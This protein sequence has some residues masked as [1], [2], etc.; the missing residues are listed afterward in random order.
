MSKRKGSRVTRA[1]SEK[2]LIGPCSSVDL[3]FPAATRKLPTTHEVLRTFFAHLGASSGAES[4]TS[5]ARKTTLKLLPLWE[6]AGVP[7]AEVRNIIQ[8]IVGVYKRYRGLVKDKHLSGVVKK[9]GSKLGQTHEKNREQFLMDI[10]KLFD[11]GHKNALNMMKNQEDI[12]FYKSM[13]SDRKAYMIGLD[14]VNRDKHVR[15]LE[16]KEAQRKAKEKSELQKQEMLQT[17]QLSGL[18]ELSVS[19]T[20]DTDDT[21][22]EFKVEMRGEN[23][24]VKVD[25]TKNAL[26][27]SAMARTSTSQYAGSMMV[28]AIVS[29]TVTQLGYDEKDVIIV[30]SATQIKRRSRENNEEVSAI[31]KQ[32]FEPT[33]PLVVHFDGKLFPSSEDAAKNADRLPIVVSGKN[34]EKLLGIPELVH[35]SG[36]CIADAVVSHVLD[37]DLK[38][39]IIGL[40]FD[41]TSTNSGRWGG[42]CILIQQKLEMQLLELACRHHVLELVLGAV[43]DK[44]AGES[45]SPDLLYGDFLK[46]SWKSLDK[47]NYRTAVSLRGVQKLLPEADEM[48]NF[49]CDQLQKYQPRDDYKELLELTIVFLGGVVPEKDPY[50]FRTPGATSKTRWMAKALYSFKIWMFGKQL[51]L[52]SAESDSF[53]RVCAFLATH[54]V[55]NWYECPVAIKAPA[56]DLQLLKNLS[57]CKEPYLKAAF[58]KLASHLWYL[59]EKLICLA[60]FDNRVTDDEKRKIVNAMKSKEGS[61]EAA[62]R[63]SLPPKKKVSSLKLSDFASQKSMDF[64]TIAKISNNFLEKDPSTWEQDDDFK[65]G[66]EVAQNLVPVN[67]VAERGV[68]LIKK[69]L[70]GNKLTNNESQ[71]QYMLQAVEKHRSMY[72][73][74]GTVKK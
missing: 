64:F 34:I 48:I 47:G 44:L 43:F 60:L 15:A 74:F 22:D 16:R 39:Q 63:A 55:K 17:R 30:G 14:T 20:E 59:S 6:A 23:S 52:S 51:K 11:I 2:W 53:F 31:I 7:T 68:A 18:S 5:A 26:V 33:V 1:G 41:T 46:S 70:T 4:A 24:R 37:W 56:N 58:L 50:T 61:L 66:L 38:E 65:R 32:E 36:Q 69:Y 71:R 9:K 49:C 45:K 25:V 35:G 21:D 19:N 10:S 8:K 29:A 28:K 54:Y 62:P 12:Q 72:D 67:D 42:A 57:D 73:K 27:T 3:S 40:V 13:Q